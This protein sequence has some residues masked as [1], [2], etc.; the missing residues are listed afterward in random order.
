VAAD[1]T[2]LAALEWHPQL[3][4]PTENSSTAT[5]QRIS[6]ANPPVDR[7]SP[8]IGR[9]SDSLVGSDLVP[10][11]CFLECWLMVIHARSR[12]KNCND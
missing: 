7:W 2:G 5:G 3:S 6:F 8:S 12:L 10:L 1:L 11:L 9:F 4:I